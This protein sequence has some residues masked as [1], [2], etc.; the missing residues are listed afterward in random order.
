MQ[1]AQVNIPPAHILI[2][3]TCRRCAEFFILK[4]Q[5]A[6]QLEIMDAFARGIDKIPLDKQHLERCAIEAEHDTIDRK[7]GI[8]LRRHA[9]SVF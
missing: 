3:Y 2:Q 8:R 4:N 1:L 6:G 9:K 5:A 7:G